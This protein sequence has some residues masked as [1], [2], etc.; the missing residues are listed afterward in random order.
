AL[1]VPA[2]ELHTSFKMKNGGEFLAL[3]EPDKTTIADAYEPEIPQ[4]DP[5][6]SYGVQN[7]EGNWVTHFFATPSPGAANSG[8]TVAEEVMF[9]VSGKAFNGSLQVELSSRSGTPI[10][11]STDGDAPSGANSKIYSTAIN[12]TET[13][14][15]TAQV[16][17]GPIHQDVY[18]SI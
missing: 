4:L 5:G 10:L 14:A 12:L 18:F 8:G 15:L 7:V 17:S 9:S 11:Y 3:V 16:T 6:Q 13:T 1:R 2:G